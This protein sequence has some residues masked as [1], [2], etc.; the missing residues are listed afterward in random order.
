MNDFYADSHD[1]DTLDDELSMD[2]DAW[3]EAMLG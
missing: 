3:I 2:T 1:F